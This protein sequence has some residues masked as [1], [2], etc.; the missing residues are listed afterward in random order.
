VTFARYESYR[1]SGADYLGDVPAHWHVRPLKHL[2]RFTSGGTPS[3]ERLE[4]WDGEIPWASAKDL[5]MEVLLDTADHITDAA[6]DEA[7]AQLVPKGAILVLVRGMMLAR[8]FPVCMVGQPMAINQDLKALTPR[9]GIRSD[10]LAWLLRGTAPET[11]NRLDE[12]GHGTKALRMDAWASMKL[13]VPP[14]PEQQVIAE[15]L[16]RETAKIDALMD[17]QRRLIELLKEKRQAVISH[18]V[19]KGLDPSAPTK[20]S[21]VEWLGAVP[22]HWEICRIANLFGESVALLSE[23]LPILSVSIHNGVSDEELDENDLERKV[24]RSEDRGKYKR[25]RPGDLVYNMMRAWQGGFGTVS[26]DGGVSPAYVVA[27]PKVDI[28]TAFVE[29][30]LR[31][32]QCVEEMRTRSVGVTDFRLRL[33]WDEFKDLKIALPPLQE[34]RRILNEIGEEIE[35]YRKLAEAAEAA[36]TLLSERRAALISAAVTGKIDVRG[37]TAAEVRKAVAAEIIRLHARK[38]TFGRVKNQKLLYLAE[39]HAGISEIGGRYARKAAGPYDADLIALV[40][41]DLEAA[42]VMTVSQPEG[43]GSTVSYSLNRSWKPDNERLKAM[44]GGR[45]AAFEQ[46]NAKLADLKTRDAE[47][48]ATL[49]AV[50]NDALIDGEACDDARVIRGFLDEW[51]PEKRE[52]FKQAELHNWVGWMR[53]NGIVPSGRGPRT[54]IGGLFG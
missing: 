54:R 14:E 19:T 7:G 26:V 33:Y 41:R 2:A 20:D 44:L 29:W 30:V 38:P 10:Y 37:W 42:G 49:Y 36:V 15:V 8:M 23:D 45:L 27:R 34:Q 52:K 5:K 6:V 16:D 13:P 12:A 39:A 43:T 1:S 53:R 51:H 17:A 24:S 3:K 11:L 47:A 9:T 28:E 48:V 31:T 40:E 50:W 35:R 18:A 4:F 25:V 32:P 22:E 21:G 46:V